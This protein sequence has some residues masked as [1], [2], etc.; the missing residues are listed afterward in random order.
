MPFGLKNTPATFQ[1]IIDKLL[2]ELPN[3]LILAYIGDIIICSNDLNSHIQDL[4]QPLLKIKNMV[5]S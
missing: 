2:S 5:F 3:I 4:K 1:R